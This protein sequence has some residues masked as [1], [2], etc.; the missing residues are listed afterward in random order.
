MVVHFLQTCVPLTLILTM[1][2]LLSAATLEPYDLLYSGGVEAFQRGD[3]GNVVRYM[4]KA[5]ENFA[6]VRQTK[7]QCGL[8]CRDQH[9]LNVT[10]T[11]FQLFDV[12]LRRAACLNDCMERQLGSP[13]VHKVS[14]DVNQD[15]HRRI[16]YNYLQLAYLKVKRNET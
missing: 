9:K 5:L 4:E 14:A 1:L 3:Y 7:I 10:A 11:D 16:P 13:S 6:Q 15:F 2:L 8:M 12:I